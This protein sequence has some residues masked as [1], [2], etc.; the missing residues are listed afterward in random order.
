MELVYGHFESMLKQPPTI[1]Q[2]LPIS[3]FDEDKEEDTAKSERKIHYKFDPDAQSVMRD[4]IPLYINSMVYKVLVESVASEQASRRVAMKNATDN[5]EEVIR[6]LTIS[7]NKSRQ[8]QITSE[9]TEIVGTTQAL[10]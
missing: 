9:L 6:K 4:I 10:E 8:A 3:G 1:L 5:S 7:L 2:L